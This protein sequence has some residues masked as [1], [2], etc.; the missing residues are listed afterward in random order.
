MNIVEM[1]ITEDKLY[2]FIGIDRTSK[3]VIVQLVDK[4]ARR[5]VW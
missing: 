1:Q 2:L 3:L 5:T 4:A